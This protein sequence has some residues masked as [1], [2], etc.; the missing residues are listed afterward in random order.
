VEALIEVIC[1]G[2][3]VRT[4]EMEVP[5]WPVSAAAADISDVADVADIAPPAPPAPPAETAPVSAAGP[6]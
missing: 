5:T 4:Q 2:E 1:E 3:W 6:S